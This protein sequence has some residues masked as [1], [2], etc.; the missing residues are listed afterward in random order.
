MDTGPTW[1]DPR[2]VRSIRLWKLL[3]KLSITVHHTDAE[4]YIFANCG[5]TKEE[6]ILQEIIECVMSLTR[7]KPPAVTTGPGV[8]GRV[9][10]LVPDG[11][12]WF[13]MSQES[14]ASGTCAALV[15][16]NPLELLLLEDTGVQT[17]QLFAHVG[18]RLCSKC[19]ISKWNQS[20][21]GGQGSG[22]RQQ[23]FIV[24]TTTANE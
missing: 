12:R 22:V 20:A 6:E 15:V 23:T 16:E 17:L 8:P 18:L 19:P 10:V 11:S 14:P 1:T 5:R 4:S 21:S 7:L 2:S 13:Q 24:K 3:H 9:G